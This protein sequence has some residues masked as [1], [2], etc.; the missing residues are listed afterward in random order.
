MSM[1]LPKNIIK[2]LREDKIKVNGKRVQFFQ[3]VVNLFKQEIEFRE[4]ELYNTF[5]RVLHEYEINGENNWN[6]DRN[7][8]KDQLEGKE[9]YTN[10]F[11]VEQ[12]LIRIFKMIKNYESKSK[13]IW[14]KCNSETYNNSINGM[15][16]KRE[17]YHLRI[18]HVDSYSEN[19]KIKDMERKL[20]KGD[21][22]T[23]KKQLMSLCH[24]SISSKFKDVGYKEI[25]ILHGGSNKEAFKAKYVDIDGSSIDGFT[26]HLK[27]FIK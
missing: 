16:E 19:K 15:L 26:Y 10:T 3:D 22:G 14:I 2:R 13:K 4:D 7:Q 5:I 18:T 6:I 11:A 23:L 27:F 17:Y 12:V 21:L 24:F 1:K 8:L 20:N 25:K 9:F